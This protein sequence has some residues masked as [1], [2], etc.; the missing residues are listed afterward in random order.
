VSL[1]A[2]SG[3][4]EEIAELVVI[5]WD[6]GIGIQGGVRGDEPA[7]DQGSGSLVPLVEAL[8]V[9]DLK[10]EC[11]GGPIGLVSV[12]TRSSA[13]A[14]RSRSSS[15]ALGDASSGSRTAS[16]QAMISSRFGNL[17]DLASR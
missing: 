10:R 14:T 6:E 12:V 2:A 1:F 3:R 4:D 7:G 9:G 15:S 16:L 8:R 5:G 17:T 13:R 11:G